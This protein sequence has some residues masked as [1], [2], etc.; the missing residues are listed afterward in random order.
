MR[1]DERVASAMTPDTRELIE[2]AAKRSDKTVSTFL[3][4]A[5]LAR[6][7]EVVQGGAQSDSEERERSGS[8]MTGESTTTT[9]GR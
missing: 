2:F 4:D 5:A 6:A 3:R 1:R 9:K 8:S 7:R